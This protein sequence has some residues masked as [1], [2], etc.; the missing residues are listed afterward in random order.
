MTE[1]ISVK[2]KDGGRAYYFDP[3][4]IKVKVGD[5]VIVETQNGT[6]FGTVSAENREVEDDSIVKPLR[7]ALRIATDRD[8]K[9]LAENKKKEAEAF[10]ICEERIAAHKLD[11]KLVGV[12][13]SFDS[14]KIVFFFT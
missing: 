4:G 12:E 6:E 8:L 14:N 2:F 13:Y 7:K 3:C 10:K 1:V 9:K 11:M 5:S